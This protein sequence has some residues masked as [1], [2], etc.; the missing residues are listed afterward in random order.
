MKRLLKLLFI[1]LL[2]VL[3]FA[4]YARYIG[5]LGLVTREYT[6]YEDI[7]NSFDGL[8]IVQ[9]SDIHYDRAIDE[10]KINNLIEEINLINPDIVIFNGDLID[11]DTTLDNKITEFL[12]NSLSKIKSK[13]GNYSVLGDNDYKNKE[14]IINIY[15]ESNF[16]YLENTR[17]II[18]K[19]NN[20]IELSGIG[21]TT[22][23]EKK[24]SEIKKEDN[25]YH[26]VITHEPDTAKEIEEKL[27]PNLI[28]A[29]HSNN[30]QINLPFIGPIIRPKYSKKYNDKYYEI[31]D[32]KLYITGG[33]GFNDFNYRLFNHPSINF[34]RINQKESN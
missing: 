14:K 16:T 23:K 26:I 17:D 29:G 21:N 3:L 25:T 27:K 10:K 2:I 1:I 8:K 31:N 28:L 34:I 6:I 20:K 30:G 24:I 5:S 22:N 33:I 32:T 13:Y 9:F 19:D 7:P 15:K 11:I 18:I 4:L 12:I